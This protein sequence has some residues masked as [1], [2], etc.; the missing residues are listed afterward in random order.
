M[1]D[2]THNELHRKPIL[3]VEAMTYA[4]TIVYRQ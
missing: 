4:V 1:E 2:Q 3:Q